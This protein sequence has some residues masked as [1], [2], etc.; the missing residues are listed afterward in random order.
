M[1]SSSKKGMDGNKSLGKVFLEVTMF[2][3]F[4]PGMDNADASSE[5]EVNIIAFLQ[6]DALLVSI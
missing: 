3:F 4:R 1:L 2:P 6:D 5:D